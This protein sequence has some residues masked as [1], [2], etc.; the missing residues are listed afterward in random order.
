M[1]RMDKNNRPIVS[2][3]DYLESVESESPP[4]A[5]EREK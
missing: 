3:I 4:D 5:K 1:Q 2:P